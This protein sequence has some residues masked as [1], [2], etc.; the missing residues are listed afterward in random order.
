MK[1][2]W[3]TAL[4][5]AVGGALAALVVLFAAAEVGLLPG[6]A[7]DAAFHD[8]L[9]AHP[10]L[11]VE[12]TNKLQAEQDSADQKA[13]QA[14]VDKLGTKAFFD[15]KLAFVTG[16]AHAKTTIVE[17]FDYNCPYCRASVPAL[18]KFYARHKNDA[19]FAFIEFPIKGPQSTL[20]ARAALAARK[21]GDKYVAFHWALMNED[22]LVDQATVLADAKKADLDVAKLESDMN[23]PDIGFAIA[24]S[25]TLAEAA[26]IDGTPAFI[27]NGRIREGAVDDKILD[28]MAKG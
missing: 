2:Q 24:A 27:I 3:K 13:Q 23:A 1:S 17:F 26:K 16:P 4:A 22:G 9:M 11:V 6:R 19:R 5:G 25:H 7:D 15:P 20:A 12:M 18:M 10:G 21:Q 14:A 8:Y 28:Q